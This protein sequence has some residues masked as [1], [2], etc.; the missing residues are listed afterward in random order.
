MAWMGGRVK[1]GE[2]QGDPKSLPGASGWT[3]VSLP[4]TLEKL[5]LHFVSLFGHG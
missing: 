2:N 3:V 5:L 4:E 1:R